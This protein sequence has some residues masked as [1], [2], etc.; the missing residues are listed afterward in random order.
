MARAE[1]QESSGIAPAR[2]Q[3]GTVVGR[4]PRPSPSN[5]KRR[6]RRRIHIRYLAKLPSEAEAKHGPLA[7]R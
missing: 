7:I 6:L 4:L 2:W 5:S 1:S 3:I